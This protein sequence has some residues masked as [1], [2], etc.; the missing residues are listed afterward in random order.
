MIRRPVGQSTVAFLLSDQRTRF[1][2]Q[3]SWLCHFQIV[4]KV[5][6]PIITAANTTRKIASTTQD[7]AD[8]GTGLM[9]WRAY[10]RAE[11]VNAMRD[12]TSRTGGRLRRIACPESP[13][14]LFRALCR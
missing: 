1:R 12:Q 13:K 2:H 9:C 3:E 11:T 5:Y 10:A 6:T 4:E 7:D 14:A 8:P